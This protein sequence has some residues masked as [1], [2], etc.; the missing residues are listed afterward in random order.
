MQ[1]AAEAKQ[2]RLHLIE[3]GKSTSPVDEKFSEPPDAA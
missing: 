2:R 3:P 1:G